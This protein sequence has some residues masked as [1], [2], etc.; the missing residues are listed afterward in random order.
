VPDLIVELGAGTFAKINL[1]IQSIPE[2][3]DVY[4]NSSFSE[5]HIWIWI[6]ENSNYYNSF[7]NQ[8][9]MKSLE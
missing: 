4:M 7:F 3:E 8:V 2:I 5:G 1:I 6:S 9:R